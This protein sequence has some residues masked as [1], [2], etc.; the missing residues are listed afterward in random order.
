[1]Y[2]RQILRLNMKTE[3]FFVCLF[4]LFARARETKGRQPVDICVMFCGDG[5]IE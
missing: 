4:S 5:K 1:M 3:L 2:H